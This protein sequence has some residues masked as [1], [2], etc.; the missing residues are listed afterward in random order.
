[1]SALYGAAG[2]DGAACSCSF[3]QCLSFPNAASPIEPGSE[4]ETV[5]TVEF[6][7]TGDMVA[8]GDKGGRVVVFAR[9]AGARSPRYSALCEFKSH[10]PEFDY[11]KSLE[12]EE[13]INQIRFCRGLGPRC[14]RLLAANDET[15]KLWRVADRRVGA[16]AGTN[17]E[18]A[19][20]GGPLRVPR[21]V[22]RGTAI[23]ATPVRSYANAHAYVL[24]LF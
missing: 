12:V 18:H 2:T 17:V 13:K 23:A 1:M 10:D 15:V 24:P 6:D 20:L 14:C 3:E 4:A 7:A 9:D 16:V 19:A 8:I 21:V 11:L 22:P 5:T